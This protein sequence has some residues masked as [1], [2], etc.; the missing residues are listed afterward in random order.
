MA[1]DGRSWPADPVLLVRCGLRPRSRVPQ[2]L[3]GRVTK[4]QP[5]RTPSSLSVHFT[6]GI[7]PRTKIHR[8]F[9]ILIFYVCI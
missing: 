9:I 7:S 6:Y 2:D 8:I 3:H 5:G 4:L 1:R